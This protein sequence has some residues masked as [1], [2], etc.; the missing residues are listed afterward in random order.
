MLRVFLLA[1]LSLP[2][3]SS[4]HAQEIVAEEAVS[5][6]AALES[7]AADDTPSPDAA[8]EPVTDAAEL[9]VIHAVPAVAPAP[10]PPPQQQDAERPPGQ[11][12]A[13]LGE[14]TAVETA[15]PEPFVP[16]EAPNLVLAT[17]LGGL[18]GVVGGFGLSW[19]PSF[20]VAGT[21]ER[22]DDAFLAGFFMGV[23]TWGTPLTTAVGIFAAGRAAGGRGNFGVT[24][25]GT[26]L[27]G[28]LGAGL[29]GIAFATEHSQGL[30]IAGV[31][32][33]PVLQWAGGVLA[34]HLSHRAHN[35]PRTDSPDPTDSP[36]RSLPTLSLHQGGA[37]L[38]WSGAF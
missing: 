24:L 32:S 2:L 15:E 33:I 35:R 6:N 17:T 8:S 31:L 3:A 38:G 9:P 25:L 29:A 11:E 4:S 27:G 1:L 10:P 7:V 36:S 26:S 21:S 34:Y 22:S 20:G 12:S 30:T 37:S 16:A 5:E 19:G 14:E 28:I 13:A 18:A 23:T